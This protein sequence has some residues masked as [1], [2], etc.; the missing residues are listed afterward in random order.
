VSGKVA[1]ISGIGRGPGRSHAIRPAQ[2]GTDIIGF[3]VCSIGE[4]RR[5]DLE[6]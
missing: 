2:E 6:R 3:D 4:D 5:A 1:F